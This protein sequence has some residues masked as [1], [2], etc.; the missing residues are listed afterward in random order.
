L[1]DKIHAKVVELFKKWGFSF[2][3]YTRTE[4]PVHKEFVQDHLTKIFNNGYIFAQETE[5]PYCKKCSRFLPDRFVEGK[6][7]YCG[8][9]HALGDQCEACGRLLEPTLLVESYCVICKSNPVIKRVK[10][11]YFDLSKFSEKLIDYINSNKQLASN[12]SKIAENRKN[13]EN[14]GLTKMQKPF[15]SLER[16]TF[17]FTR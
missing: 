3:N 6:C 15:F 7:P 12:I 17:H 5:M 14:T 8:Y 1:T 13:G 10:H 9:E 16:T 11:W 4:N 2:D